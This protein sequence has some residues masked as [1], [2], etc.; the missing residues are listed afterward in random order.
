MK[1]IL[2][3]LMIQVN[4]NNNNYHILKKIIK[5]KTMI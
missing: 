5:N 3:I 1:Q 2:I 4:K